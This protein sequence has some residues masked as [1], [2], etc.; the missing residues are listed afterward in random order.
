MP[1]IFLFGTLCHLPLLRA[2]AGCEVPGVR[3]ALRGFRAAWVA[4]QS[5]PMLERRD[6]A[7]AEGLLIEPGP[8][9][10]ERLDFYE[11]CFGYTRR[12]VEVIRD[13]API[14]AEAWFPP[15]DA[16]QSP[17]GEWSLSDW[18]AQWGALQTI[19]AG[20]VMRQRG[21]IAPEVLSARFPIIRARADAYLRAGQWRRPGHAGR[22]MPAERI[23]HHETRHTYTGFFNAE[24]IHAS[25]PRFDGAT[26]GPLARSVFRVADA[27]TVLPYDPVRDRILLVQQFRFGAYAHGDADPW[28]LEP[29]AGLIDAGETPEIA[30]RRE[31]QEEANLALRELEFVA[32]YYPSPGGVAQVLF[33][34]LALA[35][36]PDGM[37]GLGG[38]A[39]ENEDILSHLV[40]YD[41]A[42]RMLAE[43][44]MADAAQIISMQYLMLHRDRLRAGVA[45]A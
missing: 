15:A 23:D 10:L 40:P 27:V 42:L 11:A 39:D 8:E 35:D 33:S 17:G 6:G 18:A 16:A 28:L 2:V 29:V 20:E 12:K 3:A 14:A 1:L 7:G 5:W 13:G 32:R 34:Y 36:L 9:A 25:H 26:N 37:A 21:Q 41:L 24:E 43:G 30:A 44:D 19:A 31:A 45:T 22:H 4:G 38:H